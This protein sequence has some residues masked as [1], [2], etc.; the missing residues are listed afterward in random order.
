MTDFKNGQDVI[1]DGQET[2]IEKMY[3]DGTCLIRNP[4]WNWDDE[5]GFVSDGL[6]YEVLYWIRVD[7]SELKP[8]PPTSPQP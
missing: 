3:E 4:T 7:L 8:M 1:F 2:Y 5:A 6:D